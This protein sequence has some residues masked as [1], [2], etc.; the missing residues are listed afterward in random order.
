[1]SI[2]ERAKI[3]AEL[4]YKPAKVA[5]VGNTRRRVPPPA[6]GAPSH[7]PKTIMANL[8]PPA[9]ALVAGFVIGFISGRLS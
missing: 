2:A 7:W 3:E 4:G 8:L 1:M 5:R 9:A 6:I